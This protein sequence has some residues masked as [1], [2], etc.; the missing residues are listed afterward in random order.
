MPFLHALRRRVPAQDFDSRIGVGVGFVA[1]MDA[2]EAR[3]ALAASTVNAAAHRTGLRR[4]GGGNIRQRSAAFLQFVGEDSFKRAPALRKDGAVQPGF[5]PYVPSRVFN[6]S[7]RAGGHAARVHVFERHMPKPARDGQRGL[8]L[9]VLA[10]ASYLGGNLR[11]ALQRFPSPIGA[12]LLS[13]KI[14]LRL[15]LAPIQQREA[16]RQGKHFASGQRQRVGDAAIY[17]DAGQSGHGR[18]MFDF[19]SERNMPPERIG[20]HGR[21]QHSAKARARVA[22]LHP[23]DLWEADAGP[24]AVQAFNPNLAT[25]EPETVVYAL[26]ARRR[27]LGAASEEVLEGFIK[28]AQSLLLAGLRHVGNPVELGAQ[29]GQLA[30]LRHVI[31]IF[32]GLA[33]VAA[34]MVAPLFKRQIV[35]EA[36]NASERPERLR[37]FRRWMELVSESSHP[38]IANIGLGLG[39]FNM[40]ENAEIRRGRHVVYALHAHLVFVTKYRRGVLSELAIADLRTIFAK[41][42]RD[43]GAT[44]Q[45]CNGEDDHV[46]LLVTYPPKVSL[47]VLVNSLKGVSSRL[48]REWRPEVHMRGKDKALWSPSYFAGS[49]GGA[50]LSVISEYVQSQREAPAGHS[51]LPPRPKGRG[52][53]RGSR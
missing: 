53:S 48:L 50:P 20:A 33:L 36:A 31:E 52:F 5:L 35:D 32:P 22:E 14:L 43:F 12:A 25:L 23:T 27:V 29:R 30:G 39:V 45:E 34:P 26:A 24:V 49:C 10:Y 37:L 1:A 44:L 46:H 38:H 17:A 21:I 4:V 8:V 18:I 47:S 41:V 13:S 6:R 19:A 40:P 7:F 16:F 9:P 15:S 3:L 28:V 42:C 11:D 51:R 2:N